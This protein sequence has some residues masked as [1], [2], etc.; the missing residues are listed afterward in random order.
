[1]RGNA[2]VLQKIDQWRQ[3]L[4][5][6]PQ[7][8]RRLLTDAARTIRPHLSHASLRLAFICTHNSRRSQFA[9]VWATVAASLYGIDRVAVVS[10]GTEVTACH[11]H[12]IQSLQRCGMVV[13]TTTPPPN[14]RYEV[15]FA[16]DVPP[17]I[18]YSKRF[19]GLPE[20]SS[21]LFAL[22]CCDEAAEACPV[23]PGTLQRI[24]LSYRDPKWAD[25]T[26]EA[27]TAYDECRDTIGREMLFLFD[28]LARPLSTG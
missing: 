24:S 6:L 1:M 13:K 25:G 15:S 20:A 23:I 16:D 8:R 12:V 4:V 14:P 2:D 19:D 17:V 27:V 5:D 28:Q 10:A 26:A 3:Q 11:P 18:L 22:M 21:P 7:P 9:Q